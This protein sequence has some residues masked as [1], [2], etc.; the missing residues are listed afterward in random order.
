MKLNFRRKGKQ[1][2]PIRNPS[3]LTTPEALNQ[4]WSVDFMHD[5]LVYGC[6]FR[7][8][9]IVDDLNREAWS[10]EIDLNMPAL[11]VVR[12]HDRIVAICLLCMDNASGIYITNTS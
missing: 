1:R 7:T 12:V 4:N 5:V 6:R 3:P 8:F 2:L 10:I 11:R 9:N